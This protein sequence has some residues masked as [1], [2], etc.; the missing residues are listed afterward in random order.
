M[1][2]QKEKWEDKYRPKSFKDFVGN[3]VTL[4]K[5]EGF[6]LSGSIPH[7]FFYGDVGTG[8][9][10]L[11]EVI[12]LKILGE[13]SPSFIELNASD[14]REELDIKKKVLKPI[15]NASL[16]GV[17]YRVILFDEAEGLKPTAQAILKRPMEKVKNAIFIFTTNE[18]H[19]ISEA[20][21]SR[22]SRFEFKPLPDNDIIEGL[23][24][25]CQ[26][27]NILTII[28]DNDLMEIVKKVKGD[29]R[30][31]INE[32]QGIASLNNRNAEIDRIVQ[33]YM[34]AQPPQAQGVKA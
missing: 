24:R 30:Q 12:A 14:D 4:T 27:E 21:K 29:M 22:C 16:C 19:K 17:N 13:D 28:N 25:I 34:K 10:A 15:R 18:E 31:A 3:K 26:K 23:K 32:L 8:K 9:T 1:E 5:I 2:Q 33:Q 6:I 11:A 7:L 20:I